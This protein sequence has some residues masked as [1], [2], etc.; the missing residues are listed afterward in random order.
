MTKSHPA[1]MLLTAV[2]EGLSV[3]VSADDVPQTA[4]DESE[5]LPYE[6]TSVSSIAVPNAV[7]QAP[8]V[9]NR[10]PLPRLGRQQ[11]ALVAAENAN[12]MAIG[13]K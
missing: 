1:L 13:A 3:A 10:V 5:S 2:V 6:S 4:H 9:R 12:R 7:A 8:A 11:T